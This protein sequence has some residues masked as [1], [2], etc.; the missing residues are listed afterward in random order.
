MT[1]ATI[2]GRV[3]AFRHRGGLSSQL[4]KLLTWR[5]LRK[6]RIDGEYTLHCV[7]GETPGTDSAQWFWGG[8]VVTGGIDQCSTT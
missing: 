7:A 5:I 4:R 8:Q 3:T 2:Y 6:N 1:M